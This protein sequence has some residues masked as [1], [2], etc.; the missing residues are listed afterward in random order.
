MT[1]RKYILDRHMPVYSQHFFRN[2]KDR[3]KFP[4]RKNFPIPIQNEL[5]KFLNATYIF[6]VRNVYDYL[7]YIINPLWFIHTTNIIILTNLLYTLINRLLITLKFMFFH[8]FS[9]YNLRYIGSHRLPTH[10]SSAQWNF[11]DEAF[12]I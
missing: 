12:L 11:S 3:N 2:Y 4:K 6:L 9:R 10:R 7:T 8:R 1:W 5:Y